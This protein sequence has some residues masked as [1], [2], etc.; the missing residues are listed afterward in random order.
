MKRPSLIALAITAVIFHAT[1]N[2]APGSLQRTVVRELPRS[3]GAVESGGQRFVVKTSVPASQGK[4][5]L[6]QALGGAMARSGIGRAVTDARSATVRPAATVRI[7]RSMATPGWHV[8]QS[9]RVLTGSEVDTFMHELNAQPGVASVEPDRLYT[10]ADVARTNAPAAAP[11]D[12][13]YAALQWNFWDPAGGVRAEQGWEVSIG[14]GVV[15]AVIDTGIVQGNVDLAA[16][17]VPGYDM[18]SDRRISRRDTDERVAGGWDQGDWVEADYCTE[19]GSAPHEADVSSWHGSHVAGTIAQQTNNGTGL[20]GLAHGARVMPVRVLGSCGGFGSDIADGMLWAAGA[21][22]EGLPVNPNP[23]EV[24]NMSLGSGGPLACPALYQDAINQVNALGSIVVV[25]AGNWNAN[26][27]T[28]TMGSCEGVI[29]VGATRVTGGKASYSSWGTQVDLSAPGGGGAVDGDPR[30]FVFQAINAGEERPTSEYLL[31]GFTGTSMATPHVSAAVAMVQS[32]VQTPLTTAQMRELLQQTS[33]PFPVA[34][35]AN[36]PIGAGI[37]DVDTL[38]HTAIQPPCTDNC[39][40][41]ATRLQNKVDLRGLSSTGRGGLFSFEAKAG[42]PVSIMT[43]SGTGDVSLYVAAARDPSSADHDWRSIRSK[44]NTE[45][46]R[47]TPEADGT[48]FVRLTG[49][50]LGLTL[51]ARQ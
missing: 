24:L 35:A 12:P 9:S 22:V 23:A 44:S 8:I 48:Y 34:I 39:T 36:T 46:V 15:V 2:A 11:D 45:V 7:V 51:V 33:R 4:S 20:A 3:Q 41:I 19:L 29:T 13:N 10:R 49:S 32:V 21:P 47:F 28:Y 43:M 50:Y 14:E 17:V 42:A 31:A 27:G 25:A 37:L 1:A 18:I 40:P 6:G 16:N 38:L 30:G 5:A 26:A